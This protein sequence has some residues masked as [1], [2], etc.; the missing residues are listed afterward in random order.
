MTTPLKTRLNILNVKLE[1]ALG[2][3][4]PRIPGDG[5]GDGIPNEGK[6]KGGAAPA[7]AANP[8]D[9]EAAALASRPKMVEAYRSAAKLSSEKGQKALDVG[10]PALESKDAKQVKAAITVVTDGMNAHKASYAA[11]LKIP[12]PGNSSPWKHHEER[13][14]A[15][16]DLASRLQGRLKALTVK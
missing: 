5:D 1:K 4:G 2:R 13:A 11:A 9:D 6:K 7:R 12:Y 8:K 15:L 14:K 3:K 10:Y 16:G